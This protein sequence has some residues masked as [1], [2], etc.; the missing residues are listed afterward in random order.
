MQTIGITQ[1]AFSQ[2]SEQTTVGD[3]WL[4]WVKEGAFTKVNIKKQSKNDNFFL[5]KDFKIS[6]MSKVYLNLNF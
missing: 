3:L 1:G 5:N 2:M 4:Q 6:Y